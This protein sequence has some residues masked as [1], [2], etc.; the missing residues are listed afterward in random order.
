MSERAG[1]GAGGRPGARPG[2]ATVIDRRAVPDPHAHPR[3]G[4]VRRGPRAARAQRRDDPGRGRRRGPRPRR[5]AAALRRRRRRRRRHPGALPARP[6]PARSSPSRAGDLH[7]ARPQP[8]Q[9]GADR[10]RRHGLRPQLRLAVR[11]RPRPRAALRHAD[12]LRELRQAGVPAPAPAPLGRHG[13]RAGRR[14]GVGPPPRHGV[15]PPALAATRRLW[16]R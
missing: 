2:P 3:R 12:R 13:V 5:R 7:P 1:T 9:H 6:V 14:A 8:G 4:A 16:A 10:R 11:P 15:R